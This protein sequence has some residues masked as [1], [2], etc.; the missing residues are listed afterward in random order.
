MDEIK[1]GQI[2]KEVD[3]RFQR[4]VRIDGVGHGR[5]GISIRT[6]EQKDGRWAEAPRS[7]LS[8]CDAERFRGKRSGYALHQAAS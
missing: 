8:Y 4:F 5:R 2:W 1:V 6:V 7:R 3:P